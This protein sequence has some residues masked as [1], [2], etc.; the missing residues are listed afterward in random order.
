MPPTTTSPTRCSGSP[1]TTYTTRTSAGSG[2]PHG[3]YNAHLR[4]RPGRGGRA[5]GLRAGAGLPPGPGPRALLRERRPDTCGSATSHPVG[6]AGLLPAAAD[7]IASKASSART[8]PPF[9]TRRWADAF[10]ACCAD[11]L[12]AT[13]S[14]DGHEVTHRGRTTR[15]GGAR[16]RSADAD[17]LRERAHRDDV[18]E[19]MA[20]LP[21]G[22]RQAPGGG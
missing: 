4:R 6:A 20:A 16:P 12:G 17:F 19:Q 10:T 1:C 8:A 7:D 21:R 14:P 3:K 5:A 22:R 11:V 9:L 15:L 2:R 18:G 13:V